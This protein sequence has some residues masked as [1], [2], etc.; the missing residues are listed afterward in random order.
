MASYKKFVSGYALRS[1]VLLGFI[2]LTSATTRALMASFAAVPAPAASDRLDRSEKLF[3][4]S[5]CAHCHGDLGQ[6][7]E[8]GPSLVKVRERLKSKQ[9]YKQIY[10]GG[11][12]MPAF[13][14]TLTDAEI[15]HLIRYLRSNRKLNSN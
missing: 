7:T 2:V 13:G 14:N 3:A 5:G 9:I 11:Q 10:D 6:G 4:N 1:L 15:K 12:S 8:R